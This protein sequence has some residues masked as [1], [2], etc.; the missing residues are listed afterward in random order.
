MKVS[1]TYLFLYLQ[2]PLGVLEGRNHKWC[3]TWYDNNKDGHGL[4]YISMY[5]TKYNFPC[6]STPFLLHVKSLLKRG[7]SSSWSLSLFPSNEVTKSISTPLKKGCKSNTRFPPRNWSSF[8]DNSSAL[9]Y[10]TGWQ[11]AKWKVSVLLKN[12]DPASSHYHISHFMNTKKP[13]NYSL[14]NVH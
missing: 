13:H 12:T 6:V 5:L 3:E 4:I 14:T 8:P 9:I 2:H 1:L 10:T 11:E 7:N